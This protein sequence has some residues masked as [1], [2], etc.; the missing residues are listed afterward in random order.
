MQVHYN[1]LATDGKAEPDRSGIRLRLTHGGKGMRALQTA[2]V[3][4]PAF[5]PVTRDVWYADANTGFWVERLSTRAWP[6][7]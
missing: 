5:D 3:P 4:A 1:L 7:P 6:R 2:L